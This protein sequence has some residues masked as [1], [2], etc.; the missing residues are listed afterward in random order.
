M[1]E[2]KEWSRG[3]RKL[4]AASTHPLSK[5]VTDREDKRPTHLTGKN[6]QRQLKNTVNV[7]ECVRVSMCVSEHRC[8]E[9]VYEC[10]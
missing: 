5:T 9:S 2:Q 8:E 6:R 10:K 7:P 1:Y 3:W 4:Q